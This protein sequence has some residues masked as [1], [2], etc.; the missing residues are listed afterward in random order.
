MLCL[1]IL[2]HL[3]FYCAILPIRDLLLYCLDENADERFRPHPERTIVAG[4][5]SWIPDGKAEGW[6]D[7]GPWMRMFKSAR[8]W[9]G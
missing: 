7:F 9:V 2:T 1:Y 3:F 6:G 8:R 4:V 5:G